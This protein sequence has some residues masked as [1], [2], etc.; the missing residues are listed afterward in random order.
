MY[1]P[2]RPKI[3]VVAALSTALLGGGVAVAAQ[4]AGHANSATKGGKIGIFVT[5]G[6]GAV[7]KILVAGAIGDFGKAISIDKNGKVDGNGNYVNIKLQKGTFEVNAVKFNQAVNNA[8]PTINKATCSFFA[9]G[10][11]SVSLFNG[12][13]AYAGISGAPKITGSF[14]FL[15]PRVKS[16]KHKGA[17]N[18]SNNAKPLSQYSSI[19]GGGAVSFS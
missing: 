16:G 11:H 8:K 5:P 4:S 10:S 13:G 15:A 9:S 19:Q 6:K 1:V 7:D 3:V 14:A 12:T 17:C 18:L 2:R